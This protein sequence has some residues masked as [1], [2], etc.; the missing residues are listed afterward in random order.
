MHLDV[1][2]PCYRPPENWTEALSKRFFA[3]QKA[4]AALFDEIRLVVVADGATETT[5]PAYLNRLETA[6]PGVRVISYT[7]NKGKGYALRQ[8]VLNA[9]AGLYLVTDMDFPYTTESMVAI[10]AALL[11]QKGI[12]AGRRNSIYYTHTPWSRRMLSKAFRWVLQHILRQPVDDSQCGLKAFDDAG[13][14]VFLQ[15]KINRFL[16]DLEFLM[17]ANGKVP[18]SQVAVELR[19]DIVFSSMNWKII[20]HETF[21]FLRLWI[22]LSK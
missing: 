18:V 1:I 6:I 21:N 13:K 10:A 4:A 2:V 7:E 22:R 17:L 11:Q 14:A 8:G 5:G 16:F 12:V 19:N 15:T 3:F 20:V 9:D